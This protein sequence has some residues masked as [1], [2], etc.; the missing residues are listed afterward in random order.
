MNRDELIEIFVLANEF[1]EGDLLVGGTRDEL[2]RRD[3]RQALGSVRLGEID[4]TALVEDKITEALA[5]SLDG[6]IA[7]SLSGLTVAGLKKIL[8]SP[9]APGWIANS[10]SGLSSECIAA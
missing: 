7:S 10:R 4:R 1:K 8:V 3:A 2:A 9:E 6:A 5:R